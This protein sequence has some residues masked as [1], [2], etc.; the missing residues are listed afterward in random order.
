MGHYIRSSSS[1]SNSINGP[2]SRSNQARAS[3]NAAA[4]MSSGWVMVSVGGSGGVQLKEYRKLKA[5]AG[6]VPWAVCWVAESLA[7]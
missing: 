5:A 2:R 3:A 1:F 4:A 6:A 7:I